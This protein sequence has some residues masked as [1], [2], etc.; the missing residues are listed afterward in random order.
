M[1]FLKEHISVVKGDIRRLREYQNTQLLAVSKLPSEVLLIIFEFLVELGLNF[2]GG[3]TPAKQRARY[4]STTF[5]HLRI[6][7]VCRLWRQ[8]A[9][10]SPQIWSY[11]FG[12][13]PPSIVKLFLER[14]RSTPLYLW[15]P[16]FSNDESV[17]AVLDHLDRLVEINLECKPTWVER[18][19]SQPTP[20]LETLT[21]RKSSYAESFQFTADAFPA[22]QHLSLTGYVLKSSV[23][24]LVNLR[25]L[26]IDSY[27]ESPF[28]GPQ[29]S[30]ARGPVEFFAT[31]DGLPFLTS[32]ILTDAFAPL[33]GPIPPLSVTLPSLTHLSIRDSDISNLG[34]MSRITAPLVKTIKLTHT[35]QAEAATASSVIAAI[36]SNYV[37]IAYSHSRLELRVE[38]VIPSSTSAR[39]QLWKSTPGA[40][41]SI[42]FLDLRVS[43]IG[44]LET[45]HILFSLCPSASSAST[46]HFSSDIDSFD[47][48]PLDHYHTQSFKISHLQTFRERTLHQMTDVTELYCDRPL[49]IA[50]IL[51]DA[52]PKTQNR[53]L[54]SLKKIV[55]C[56]D[57]YIHHKTKV[58]SRLREQLCAR[59]AADAGVDSWE[60]RPR[61]LSPR[62]I[63]S[64][65]G[66]I[67]I[68]ELT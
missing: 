46:F 27:H 21:L 49:D 47:I 57:R 33:N 45:E 5:Y 60:I 13:A 68:V 16:V 44:D 23:A 39:V 58:L 63:E 36:Y 18:I 7:H 2:P 32:L 11:I 31:L 38:L 50:L 61:L 54:P 25:T 29:E 56:S 67:D 34:M 62:D 20:K 22:L 3:S 42:P 65:T 26:A 1:E 35:G 40:Q 15:S 8:V 9:L 55:L 19:T 28:Y 10:D 66:I 24:S 43:G 6:T 30:R 4:V 41:E 48:D 59:K 51:G 52:P 37:D 17:L 14:A 64:F 12:F 53:S